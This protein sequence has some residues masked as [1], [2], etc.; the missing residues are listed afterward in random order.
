M[1]IIIAWF[2]EHPTTLL[3]II[4]VS[5]ILKKRNITVQPLRNQYVYVIELLV[6]DNKISSEY[7]N[8]LISEYDHYDENGLIDDFVL[9]AYNISEDPNTL[10]PGVWIRDNTF[11]RVK[12]SCF[13]C[14][15]RYNNT[16]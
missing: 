4:T 1:D 8:E 2:S 7:G 15:K 9:V 10:N 16:K 6:R 13:P 5:L 14:R 11:G 12:N 3:Q